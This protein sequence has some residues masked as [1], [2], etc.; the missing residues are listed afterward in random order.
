MSSRAS[1]LPRFCDRSQ[2]PDPPR[3][4]SRASRQSR[5]E[6]PNIPEDAEDRGSVMARGIDVDYV[7]ANI[8][9][10]SAIGHNRRSEVKVVQFSTI[11]LHSQ[12]RPSINVLQSKLLGC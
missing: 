6:T 7:S 5:S 12:W 1:S 8:E 11:K 3:P 9:G 2:S 4:T 10:A